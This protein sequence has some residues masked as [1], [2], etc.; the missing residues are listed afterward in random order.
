[1]SRIKIGTVICALC[2]GGALTPLIAGDSPKSGLVAWWKLDEK[3]GRKVSDSSGN[4]LQGEFVGNPVWRSAGRIGGTL[5]FSGDGDY[6]VIGNQPQFDLT[7]AITVAAWIK[8]NRFDRN[9]QSIVGKGDLSWR[10]A[11]D[12][13]RDC[14]QFAFNAMPQEQLLK[15]QIPVND[16]K[17][18]HVAGVYDGHTMYL[19]VDGKLDLSRETTTDIPLSDKPVY[20]GENS[21]ATGRFWNGLIDDV[22]V[23]NRPLNAVEIAALSGGGR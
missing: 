7:K 10:I 19:Y 6:V 4:G 13:D 11:R 22:R 18:H 21:Q 5:E 3:S 14:V 15:G 9:W 1:M 17:W 16:G 23:Y 8:V 20:I 12:R 2:I